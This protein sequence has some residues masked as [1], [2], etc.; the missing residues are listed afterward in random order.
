MGSLDAD[1]PK[2]AFVRIRDSFGSRTGAADNAIKA[3]RA[4]Y[5]WG[6]ERGFPEEGAVFSVKKVHKSRGGA[7]PWSPSDEAAFLRRHGPGSMARRWFFLARNTV[8]RIGDMHRLGP[9]YE[10]VIEGRRSIYWQPS[11]RGSKAVTV[12][13]LADLAE[14]LFEDQ[15]QGTTY[16]RTEVGKPFG[17]PEALRNRIQKWVVAAGLVDAMG[18]AARSQHGVRKATSQEL[19]RSGATQYEIMSTSGHVE[20]KT[21]EVYTKDVERTGLSVVAINRLDSR[22]TS[23][24]A[25]CGPRSLCRGPHSAEKPKQARSGEGGW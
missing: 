15:G 4:A 2:R 10:R 1:L 12:P 16:L 14:E 20:A 3:L 8:G 13:M 6:A 25:E 19:A 18:K 11:K 21:S 9:S 5:T 17:S 7:T 23:M 24:P 22:L